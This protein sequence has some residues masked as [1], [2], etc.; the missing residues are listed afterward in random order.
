MVFPRMTALCEALW[1]Q[2]E[3]KNYPDFLRRLKATAIPRYQYWNSSWFNNFEQWGA[4][5]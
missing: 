4:D 2:P 5:K 1:V 3:R